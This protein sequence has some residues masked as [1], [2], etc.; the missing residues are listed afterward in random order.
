MP[1][2]AH[3]DLSE[4]FSQL[5]NAAFPYFTIQSL[6]VILRNKRRR[7]F[8]ITIWSKVQEAALSDTDSAFAGR[9]LFAQWCSWR[10]VRGCIPN[11]DCGIRRSYLGPNQRLS[12]V[13]NVLR[14]PRRCER[15]RACRTPEHFNNR[16]KN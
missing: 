9:R 16:R 7:V 3:L 5:D 2:K 4:S 11:V 6:D 15:R 12:V 10:G 8:Q 13:Q 1:L 14:R